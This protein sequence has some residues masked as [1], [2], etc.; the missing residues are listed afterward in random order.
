MF[1]YEYDRL[2]FPQRTLP[3]RYG[4]TRKR[5]SLT[6]GMKQ[7]IGHFA[8]GSMRSVLILQCQRL[9]PR[10]SKVRLFTT[11]MYRVAIF[12][13]HH[14]TG[15]IHAPT[16]GMNPALMSASR[17][18]K[19]LRCMPRSESQA[20]LQITLELTSITY[21]KALHIHARCLNDRQGPLTRR[22]GLCSASDL[23]G[24]MC[25]VEVLEVLSWIALSRL[26]WNRRLSGNCA[27]PAPC[28]GIVIHMGRKCTLQY[29]NR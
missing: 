2:C 28:T 11:F 12:P 29:S 15:V 9:L 6:W 21:S 16:S 5:V 10:S 22:F 26:S 3:T 19:R 13:F 18:K 7:T 14:T 1:R 20:I 27:T 25:L 8:K 4:V 17:K 23:A 24:R